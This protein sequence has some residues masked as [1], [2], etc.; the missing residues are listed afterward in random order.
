MDKARLYSPIAILF[1][2]RCKLKIVARKAKKAFCFHL[3]WQ[4]SHVGI[5]GK[6]NKQQKGRLDLPHPGPAWRGSG[7]HWGHDMSLH[8]SKNSE[9]VPLT[10]KPQT[11][12]VQSFV[13]PGNG[14]HE[15]PPTPYLVRVESPGLRW[16]YYVLP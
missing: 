8:S 12:Y 1:L 2:S 4:K 13:N 7:L 5:R 11:E 3:V 6:V 16:E 14:P 9:R 10:P 15:N